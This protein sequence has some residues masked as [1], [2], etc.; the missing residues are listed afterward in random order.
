MTNGLY[1]IAILE[2]RNADEAKKVVEGLDN[3]PMDRSHTFHVYRYADVANVLENG[4]DMVLPEKETYAPL[5]KAQ[6]QLYVLL[7]VV[8]CSDDLHSY[9][10]DEFQRDQFCIR[11]QNKTQFY[12]C[13]S[14][15]P[16]EIT[17]SKENDI[18]LSLDTIKW[19]PLGSFLATFH[20]KGIILH[21][22][23]DFKEWGRLGHSSVKALDF[24]SNERYA[25]T[26]NGQIGTSNKDAVCVWDIASNSVLRKFPCINPNW[27]SFS[28]SADEK[29]LATHGSNGIGMYD[30]KLC[31][32]VDLFS[33]RCKWSPSPASVF[34]PSLNTAGLPWDPHLLI[35]FPKSAV[36]LPLWSSS[37]C[38]Q[39]AVFRVSPSRMWRMFD[40]PLPLIL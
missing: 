5:R 33:L 40:F 17:L 19:S 23:S 27:P 28:I 31:L 4:D 3:T 18:S 39:I 38:R 6:I 29:F 1:R 25:I 12:W 8:E 11:Y 2:M 20:A 26:W 15:R 36:N 22:G 24:S 30:K 9:M 21:G 7:S 37:M 10:N 14:P 34:L 32:S 16:E 35:S 13:D